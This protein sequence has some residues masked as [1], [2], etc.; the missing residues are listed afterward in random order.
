MLLVNNGILVQKLLKSSRMQTKSSQ[1]MMEESHQMA[2]DMRKDSV[3]M[4]TVSRLRMEALCSI[5]LLADARP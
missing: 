1:G 4:K 2:K 3:S 5:A